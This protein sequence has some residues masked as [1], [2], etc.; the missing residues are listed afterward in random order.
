MIVGT[1]IDEN[2][3]D[4]FMEEIEKVSNIRYSD[5]DKAT[6]K[7]VLYSTAFVGIKN[8]KVLF[9]EGIYNIDGE[10]KIISNN[11]FV[12]LCKE[13]SPS[14]LKLTKENIIKELGDYSPIKEFLAIFED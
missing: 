4:D 12:M 11:K 7:I 10:F 2:Y 6:Y 1:V 3:F 5:G 13:K 8:D 14:K 9:N